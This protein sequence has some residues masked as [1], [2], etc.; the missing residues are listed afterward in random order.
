MSYK[1]FHR[2]FLAKPDEADDSSSV[3]ARVNSSDKDYPYLGAGLRFADQYDYIHLSFYGGEEE[4]IDAAVSRAKKL[5]DIVD[6]FY[7]ALEAE[8]KVVK[9]SLKE[10]K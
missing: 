2:E 5:K 1:F 9:K 4:E 3:I 10:N 7:V 8:A 6:K